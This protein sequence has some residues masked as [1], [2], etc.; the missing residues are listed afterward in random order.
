MKLNDALPQITRRPRDLRG[1]RRRRAP[2][3]A[4]R[5]PT[6]PL[7]Q[8]YSPVLSDATAGSRW[9]LL[10]LADSAFPTGGFAHSGGLEAAVAAR[11]APD[12]GGRS[13]RFVARAPV[14]TRAAARCRSCGAAFD[15]PG[16]RLR[17]STRRST[18]RSSSHVANRASRTQGRAF[19]RHRRARLR[20]RRGA[21]A[22]GA[23]ARARSPAHLAPVFGAALAR[24]RRRR[25][26]EALA[27]YLYVALRGVALGGGAARA[28]RAARGAAPAARAA[29]PRSTRC[30]PSAPTLAPRRRR[31]DARRCSTLRRARTIA[32]TRA[33]SSPEDDHATRHE[34]DHDHAARPRSR[35]TGTRTS[36][37]R[38]R[39][40]SASASRRSR[41]D[42]AQRAF[43]VGIGGPVGSGK[44]ALVLALCR[45]APRPHAPRR[46]DER[47]LHARR[48]RVPPPQRGARRRSGS[49]PSRPAAAR[50]P[51]SA[52]TSATTSRAR[53]AHGRRARPSCSSSRAAATTSPRSTAASSSTT[54]STSSTSPAATRSRARAGP[55]ITQSRSARHQQDRPRA[56]RRREPRGDGARRRARCAA[57]GPFVFAQANRG[58][59]LDAIIGAILSAWREVDP[60]AKP[61]AGRP[62]LDGRSHEARRREVPLRLSE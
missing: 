21:R 7:A 57:T 33:V 16:E 26:D 56:A 60:A 17:R 53:A 49:A 46:R 59:G 52:R 61:A 28:R 45:R 10:Q 27:L 13:T 6:L 18:R 29:A 15:A 43:T 20:R 1:P 25:G 44:T 50:T 5:R 4:S 34:H 62:R 51:R 48:R 54:R 30:S 8:L 32:S 11:R 37:G 2:H 58:V 31:A 12:G 39:A 3:A 22:R 9:Q 36:T 23:R 14:A 47:H 40:A 41:R 24:A 38:T 55:G 42:Y 35:T 19:A